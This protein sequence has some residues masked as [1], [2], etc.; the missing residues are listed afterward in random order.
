MVFENK[1]NLLKF[2][3]CVFIYERVL[4]KNVGL[5]QTFSVLKALNILKMAISTI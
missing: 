5:G 4:Q 1:N 3:H 2:G